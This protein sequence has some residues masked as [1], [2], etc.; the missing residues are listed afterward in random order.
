MS[1]SGDYFMFCNYLILIISTGELQLL[2]RLK[3]V[4]E[5][6]YDPEHGCLEGT[7]LKFLSTVLA[8]IKSIS[9]DPLAC[10]VHG[11]AGTGKSTISVTLA[12]SLNRD[13]VL[14]GCFMFSRDIPELRDPRRVLPTLSRSLA[15]AHAPYRDY[16]LSILKKD[17]EICGKTPKQQLDDL[18]P[19]DLAI[20][21]PKAP[22]VFVIGAL[23]ECGEVSDRSVIADCLVQLT[24]NVPWLRV[25][26]TSRPTLEIRR[27]LGQAR[28]KET[29]GKQ[30]VTS[31]DLNE[32]EDVEADIYIFNETQLKN[33]PELD[34]K[35]TKPENLQKLTVKANGLF[36]WSSTVCKYVED[37]LDRNIALERVIN[38][39][40]VSPSKPNAVLDKLYHF[41]LS[42]VCG[43]QRHVKKAIGIIASTA[44]YRPLTPKA[45]YDLFPVS[46][47]DEG[48]SYT[49]LLNT[50]DR[51]Q[52]VLFIDKSGAVR[53]C[54]PSF[55][56]FSNM[57]D[58][59]GDFWTDPA[60]IHTEVGQ[61]C[62]HLMKSGL[63]FNICQLES[64]Y[65]LNSDVPD[66]QARIFVN[67][68]K[69]LRYSC[70]HWIDHLLSAKESASSRAMICDFLLSVQSLYWLEALSLMKKVKEGIKA[71][72]HC[73]RA[74]DVR[75]YFWILFTL[76]TLPSLGRGASGGCI[77]R[78]IQVHHCILRCYHK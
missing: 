38:E 23:D 39:T 42:Q 20:E 73:V 76:L 63:K 13:G 19:S 11:V 2:D 55:L 58:R 60:E 15:Q 7:R 66:L 35:W 70:V 18:F 29:G 6:N 5:A 10:W 43:E 49:A 41:V 72:G 68:P 33:I 56:D 30:H 36:I 25:I 37:E 50:L 67:I 8:K 57:K 52:S 14:G 44:D 74:F 3:S 28:T 53:V 46:L 32:A 9:N 45:L 24:R 65:V 62:I 54:H 61:R 75:H 17:T 71:L 48:F 77:K 59:A 47:T 4:S 22:L 21:K 64:A 27:V 31:Y 34:E 16:I 1:V 12:D 69:S 51:L 78:S 26:A 40:G